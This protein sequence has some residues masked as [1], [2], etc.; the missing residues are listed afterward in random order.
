VIGNAMHAHH[1]KSVNIFENIFLHDFESLQHDLFVRKLY[2][3]IKNKIQDVKGRPG[4]KILVTNVKL[5][6]IST[7]LTM[8]CLDKIII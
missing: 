6:S 2:F 4:K 1:S 7:L 8:L 5:L 3:K